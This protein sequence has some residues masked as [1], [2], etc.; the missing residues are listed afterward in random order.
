MQVEKRFTLTNDFHR[1]ISN[2]FD[3]ISNSFIDELAHHK[4]E[5]T[6]LLTGYYCQERGSVYDYSIDPGTFEIDKNGKGSFMANFEIYYALDNFSDND[7]M[8]IEFQIDLRTGEM[9]LKG[10]TIV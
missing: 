1:I 8:K 4:D 9:I 6:G 2:S 10:E 7:K 5:L 3:N